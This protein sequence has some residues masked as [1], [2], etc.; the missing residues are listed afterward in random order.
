M[1]AVG[2]T[3]LGVGLLL[4]LFGSAIVGISIAAIG[5]IVL[6]AFAARL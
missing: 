2:G 3:L 6:I 5:G 1:A 4:I